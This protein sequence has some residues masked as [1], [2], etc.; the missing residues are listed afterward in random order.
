M[1]FMILDVFS[2]L[3][4]SMICGGMLTP[5]VACRLLFHNTYVQCNSVDSMASVMAVPM[6]PHHGSCL[7]WVWYRRCTDLA[8][9]LIPLLMPMEVYIQKVLT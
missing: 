3:N 1:E 8:T 6:H 7:Y 4:D 9:S 2:N 5:F